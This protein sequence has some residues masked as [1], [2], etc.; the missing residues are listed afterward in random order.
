MLWLVWGKAEQ[1]TEQLFGL[2]MKFPTH[3]MLIS[4][5]G[6]V[7]TNDKICPQSP[8]MAVPFTQK[9]TRAPEEPFPSSSPI[10]QK[11]ERIF[12]KDPNG[13]QGT[14][15]EHQVNKILLKLIFC[16]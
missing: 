14:I 10:T 12:T 3:A 7:P 16:I 4:F 5:T 11:R 2:A 6:N 1:Q 13:F 15:T 8:G 9:N